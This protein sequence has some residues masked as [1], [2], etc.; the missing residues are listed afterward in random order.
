MWLNDVVLNSKTSKYFKFSKISTIL[1]PI[2]GF[3]DFIRYA[4]LMEYGGIC[5]WNVRIKWWPNGDRLSV[6][7]RP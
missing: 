3:N 5:K 7:Y 6:E 4:L 2:V 1:A